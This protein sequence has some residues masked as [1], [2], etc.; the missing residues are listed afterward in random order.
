MRAV[1]VAVA[2]GGDAR[3][4]WSLP[5]RTKGLEARVRDSV[6]QG[7]L[8]LEVRWLLRGGLPTSMIEWFSGLVGLVETCGGVTGL[9]CESGGRTRWG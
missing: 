5:E 4:K 7:A 1:D 8:T 9:A 6:A 3:S 2:R